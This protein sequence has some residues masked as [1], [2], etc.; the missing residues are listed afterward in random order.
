MLSGF[1]HIVASVLHSFLF[2]NNIP[3]YR[4]TMFCLSIHHLRHLCFFHLGAIMN[5]VSMNIRVQSF[6]HMFSLIL[7]I[8]LD[9]VLLGNMVNLNLTFWGTA[10]LFSKVTT[11]LHSHRQCMSIP[12]SPHSY[13]HLLFS[14]FFYYKWVWRVLICIFPMTNGVEHLFMCLLVICIASLKKCLNP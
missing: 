8:Y 2:P 3:L 13:Q 5:N 7:G 6:G 11:I 1:I 9:L 10:K 12:I 4:Y 14:I